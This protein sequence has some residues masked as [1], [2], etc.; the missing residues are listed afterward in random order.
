MD[1]DMWTIIYGARLVLE[2]L[3]LGLRLQHGSECHSR[4]LAEHTLER[5]QLQDVS[6][7]EEAVGSVAWDDRGM[8]YTCDESGAVG[9]PP[10]LENSGCT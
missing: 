4:D 3:A 9:F 2:L 1:N 8:D 5:I 7:V 6:R 10:S